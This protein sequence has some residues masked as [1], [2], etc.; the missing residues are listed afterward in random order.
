MKPERT[1]LTGAWR[2][3]VGL[4]CGSSAS[5]FV[6]ERRVAV[7]NQL[8]A[9]CEMLP[10]PVGKILF[11]H[12][13]GSESEH[14][15]H[16]LSVSD[17]EVV[18]IDSEKRDDGEKANALIAVPVGMVLHETE[19]ICGGQRGEISLVGV[20]PLLQWPGEGGIQS[21]FVSNPRQPAVFSQLVGVNG[22]DNNPAQPTR[23]S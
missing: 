12:L 11:A 20:C 15:G 16:D 19:P 23:L 7:S 5:H 4:R 10:N 1:R 17:I 3:S 18:V 6:A 22:I 21:V 8:P 13:A 14:L 2:R 9:C